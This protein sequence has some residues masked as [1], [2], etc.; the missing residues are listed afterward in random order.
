MGEVIA[1]VIDRERTAAQSAGCRIDA[2]VDPGLPLVLGD[3]VALRHAVGNLVNNALKYGTE[4]GN[5]IGVSAAKV[6]E[7]GHDWVELRVADRGPGIPQ[8]EQGHIFDPFFRGRRAREDQV[9][10]SGLGLNLVMRIVRAHGGT[11]GV[12]S[13]PTKGAEFVVRLPAARPEFQDE[14]ANSAG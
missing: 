11:V 13:E 8:N 10:G 5:W 6:N 7:D 1:D 14:F 2:S 9:H 3:S 12:N 4:G